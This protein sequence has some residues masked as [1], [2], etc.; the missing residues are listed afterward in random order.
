MN[1]APQLELRRTQER[2]ATMSGL[3]KVTLIGNLGK[4][5]E[6]KE[7]GNSKVCKFSLATSSSWKDKDGNRQEKTEW[8]NIVAWGKTGEQLAKFLKKGSRVYLEGRIEYRKY[9]KDGETKYITEVIVADYTLLDKKDD[10]GG[11]G[12]KGGHNDDDMSF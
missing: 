1:Q 10:N 8:H 7:A 12:N 2:K 3:N 4:D 11:G 5:P 6:I 9:E